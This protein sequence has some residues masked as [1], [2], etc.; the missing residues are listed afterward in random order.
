MIK[1]DLDGVTQSFKVMAPM[2]HRFDNGKKFAVMDIVVALS[3]Y[4]FTGEKGNRVPM[5]IMEL[6]YNARYRK[7]RGIDM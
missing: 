1:E 6:A 4:A 2:S 5:W 7:S 3:R